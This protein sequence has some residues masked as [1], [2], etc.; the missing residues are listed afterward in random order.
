[1]NIYTYRTWSNYWWELFS[2]MAKSWMKLKTSN[3]FSSFIVCYNQTRSLLV[4]ELL[5]NNSLFVVQLYKDESL[6]LRARDLKFF[7]TNL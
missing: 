2:A 3:V 6:L 7:T 5:S 1:M 4:R